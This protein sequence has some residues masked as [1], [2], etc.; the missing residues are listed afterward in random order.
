[1]TT[2]TTRILIIWG[3]LSHALA[4]AVALGALAVQRKRGPYGSRVVVKSWFLRSVPPQ[5]AA[6]VAIPF[7]TLPTI[8][9]LAAVL[10]FWGVVVPGSIWRQMAVASA[11]IS[12]LGIVL[13]SG[14]WPGSQNRP[15]NI[16]NT[17]IALIM[18]IAVLV[19]LLWLRWPP[20]DLFGK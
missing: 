12:V 5:S 13:F 9:F 11:L 3:L 8:G 15:R 6:A 18:N 4:H 20:V 14:T 16:L 10:S 7:W 19:S 1:M 2:S 17:S